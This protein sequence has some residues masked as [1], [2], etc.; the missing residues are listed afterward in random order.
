MQY[1]KYI[2]NQNVL[3]IIRRFCNYIDPRLMEHG[4]HVSYL[5]YRMLRGNKQYTELELRNICF[6]ALLHDVGAYKTEDLSNMIQFETQYVWDHSF[7]GYF[8][9]RY[10]SPLKDLAP[11]VI[12]HHVNWIYLKDE[13]RLSSKIIDLSQLVHLADYIDICMSLEKRSWD[14]TLELLNA[15]KGNRFAPHLVELTENLNFQKTIEEEWKYDEEY[16]NFLNKIP[17]SKEEITDYLKMLVFIIDFRSRDTVTHTIAAASISYE[18]GR[19]LSLSAERVDHI[20]YGALIHD[21]GKIAI[22]VEILEHPG[23]LSHEAM[24]IMKTHVEFTEK[25]LEGMMDETIVRIAVRHHEKLDGFGYPRKLTAA[26]LTVEERL[27]AIADII[28][29]L[30]G[31]RSYKESYS[32]ERISTILIKMKVDGYLDPDIVDLAIE[33]L[34]E[35][36]HITSN[37]C[38]PLLDIYAQLQL[39]YDSLHELQSNRDKI[40]F[41]LSLSEPDQSFIWP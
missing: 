16:S 15:E 12:L 9:I 26:D 8:F 6:M 11:A 2:N 32:N 35:I 30:S 38:Q 10:F 24:M 3:G 19:Q 34:D 13:K 20:L 27:V 1:T 39:E 40:I 37:R 18:L 22:P 5:V 23:R 33:H 25:I 7:Y 36:L 4:S 29:A 31:K 41:A 28:S 14:Q 21:L 17:L